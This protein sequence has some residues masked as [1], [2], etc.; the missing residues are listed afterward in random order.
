VRSSRSRD[1]L[2]SVVLLA[3]FGEVLCA[4]SFNFPASLTNTP[5]LIL[6]SPSDAEVG[7]LFL[8]ACPLEDGNEVESLSPSMSD[9]PPNRGL[10]LRADFF[11][12][13]TQHRV[14]D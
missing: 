5:G 6:F 3:M 7:N 9:I 13:N 1:Q 12:I 11:I 8:D 14:A 4:S 2:C 10:L